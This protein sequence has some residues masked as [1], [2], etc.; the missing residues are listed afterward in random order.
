MDTNQSPVPAASTPPALPEDM[1]A[2]QIALLEK[3]VEQQAKLLTAADLQIRLMHE[4]GVKARVTNIGLPFFSAVGLI[5]ELAIASI[6]V[7]IV[8][9]IISVILR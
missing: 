3:I 4:S 1:Q 5:L 9:G 6:P 7:A 8:W 2:R